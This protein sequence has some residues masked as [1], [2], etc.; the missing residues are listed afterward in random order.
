M[1]YPQHLAPPVLVRAQV[2]PYPAV[3]A[4]TP[5]LR[6]LTST[7]VHLSVIEL[8][9]SWPYILHPQHLSPPVLVTAQVCLIPAAMVLSPLLRP[10]TSTGV[11][12]SLVVPLPSWP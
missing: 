1:L 4:L 9:P 10:L 5:L 12:L 8:S 7:G 6:L 11:E 2:C 3:R